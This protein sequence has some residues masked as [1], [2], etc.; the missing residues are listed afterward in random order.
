MNAEPMRIEGAEIAFQVTDQATKPIVMARSEDKVVVTYG[1]DAAAAALAP[2]E[3]LG[4]SDLYARAE[5][6]LGDEAE[7]STLLSIPAI[8]RFNDAAG[9][10]EWRG[11]S[12]TP[13]RS[14]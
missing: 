1:T 10:P 8:V 11:S 4:N 3:Q 7:P 12:R 2:D 5:E 9:E 13:R 14:T 6:L